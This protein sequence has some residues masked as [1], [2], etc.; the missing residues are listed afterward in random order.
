MTASATN[1]VAVDAPVDHESSRNDR[2]VPPGERE[3]L[4]VERKLERPRHLVEIEMV[5]RHPES[6]PSVSEGA[7]APFDDRLVPPGLDEGDP[8]TRCST[9]VWPPSNRHLRIY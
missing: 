4:G 1:L 9:H 5:T 8:L 3:L 2:C 6:R 7:S